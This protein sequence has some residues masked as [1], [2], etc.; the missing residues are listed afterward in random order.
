MAA[1]STT[2]CVRARGFKHAC[3][4][5]H[6]HFDASNAL[7]EGCLIV[8]ATGEGLPLRLTYLRT[9]LRTYLPTYS[10]TYLLTDLLATGKGLPLRLQEVFDGL[11]QEDMA[12]AAEMSEEGLVAFLNT[13]ALTAASDH[14]SMLL[15]LPTS[16]TSSPAWEQP[17]PSE[18]VRRVPSAGGQ[19][20]GVQPTLTPVITPAEQTT[21]AMVGV[22][23]QVE[24]EEG[25]VDESARSTPSLLPLA[26]RM[27]LNLEV[28]R[29]AHTAC[30]HANAHIH[31]GALAGAHLHAH[32]HAHIQVHVVH[33]VTPSVELAPSSSH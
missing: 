14:D 11:M 2:R 30:A 19:E 24:E 6:V 9:Y 1:G 10:L 32:M 12:A 27:D 23:G 8:C 28:W 5:S 3:A 20:P 25:Q 18:G 7:A 33:H 21:P 26:A 29:A 16:T 31:A 15:L 17:A 13:R 22:V 4:F